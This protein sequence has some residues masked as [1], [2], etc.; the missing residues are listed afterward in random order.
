MQK[1]F[2]HSV[3]DYLVNHT[4]ESIIENGKLL[5]NSKIGK[6]PNNIRKRSINDIK[7]TTVII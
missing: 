6:I 5:W 3:N 1:K 4:V 2:N 7:G